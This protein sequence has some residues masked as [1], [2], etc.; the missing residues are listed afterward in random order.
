MMK[1]M[2]TLRR[3]G[4]TGPQRNQRG[5]AVPEEIHTRKKLAVEP[6]R[7][8]P[9]LITFW[10]AKSSTFLIGEDSDS[11]VRKAAKLAV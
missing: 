5:P 2:K 10:L 8:A 7:L 9:Y 4:S 1:A 6:P 11:T 3:I